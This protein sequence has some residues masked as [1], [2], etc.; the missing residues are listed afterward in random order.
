MSRESTDGGDEL[1]HGRDVVLA[2][3]TAHERREHGVF[4]Q[5]YL[6]SQP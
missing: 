2:R 4:Q 1:L 3:R 5:I 6:L